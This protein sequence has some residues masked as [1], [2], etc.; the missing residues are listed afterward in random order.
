[1]FFIIAETGFEPVLIEFM[2]LALG[3]R[4][5]PLRNQKA[6]GWIRTNVSQQGKSA[7]QAGPFNLSG[8]GAYYNKQGIGLECLNHL[9]VSL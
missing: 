1:M 8:T 7:L 6:P 4:S 9:G 2:R 5:S 3:N